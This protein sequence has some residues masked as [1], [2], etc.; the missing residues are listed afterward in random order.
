VVPAARPIRWTELRDLSRGRRGKTYKAY[1]TPDAPMLLQSRLVRSTTLEQLIYEVNGGGEENEDLHTWLAS[2]VATAWYKLSRHVLHPDFCDWT[3]EV[4]MLMR[5]LV[6]AVEVRQVEEF[7]PREVA[8]IMYAWGVLKYQRGPLLRA[9]CDDAIR[10]MGEYDDQGL[11]N[12]V[13]ALGRLKT[14]HKPL[15]EAVGDEVPRRLETETFG[16]QELVNIVYAFSRLGFRHEGLL[17]AVSKNVAPRLQ[18]FKPQE[19]S[20]MLFAMSILQFRHRGFLDAMC[21][22]IPRRLKS[23]TQQNLENVVYAVGN[24]RHRHEEFAQATA[25]EVARRIPQFKRAKRVDTIIESLKKLQRQSGGQLDPAVQEASDRAWGRSPPRG[26]DFADGEGDGD[27]EGPGPGRRNA[28]RRDR[29]EERWAARGG[30]NNGIPMSSR[31]AGEDSDRGG[32]GERRGGK[33]NGDY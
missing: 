18:E 21:D 23:F 13:Y 31:D 19:L 25:L 1:D 12:V 11:A 32:R 27:R 6:A 33:R 8:N 26:Q 2:S 30:W 4:R 10:R 22:H 24:L 7:S 29:E 14:P 17:R 28:G 16:N 5:R 9:F 20:N 3:P 15:L